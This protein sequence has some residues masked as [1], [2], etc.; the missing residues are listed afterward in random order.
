MPAPQKADTTAWH[1]GRLGRETGPPEL[2]FGRMYE[3]SA[4]ELDS[5]EPGRRVFCIASAGCTAFDL[6]ARGDDVTAVDVNPEQ[7]E[8]V[9][10][11]I[12]GEPRR[13]GKVDR[14]LDRARRLAPAVGW[15]RDTLERFCSLAKP[16]D[17]VEFWRRRLDTRRFRVVLAAAF[18]P[19]SLRRFYAP[20]LVSALPPRFD[21]AL[22]LRFDRGFGRHPNV[23]NPYVASLFLG[24][25]RETTPVPV[26]HETA[27]AAEF[28][29]RCP[30]GTFDG[31]SLSN[32]LD[33]ADDRYAD[34][35]FASIKRAATPGAVVILRSL[36]EP[37]SEEAARLAADD[38]S[39]I[40]GAI[41][42]E[43]V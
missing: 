35:L 17:Q 5:F 21:R 20:P 4:L 41:R 26:R 36:A 25:P 13:T 29:E 2:L 16:Q 12:A 22:R 33:G 31:F 27:D 9:R 10:E 42:I 39:P 18:S 14:A 30:T 28:L 3:D 40:W 38:R 32:V 11:R 43:R 37:T 19:L 8:Y 15:S 7:I 1:R 23:G 6:A 24:Q 34:R